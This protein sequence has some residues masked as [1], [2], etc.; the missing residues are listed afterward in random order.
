MASI[1]IN[2]FDNPDGSTDWNA[3]RKAKKTNGEECTECG[4]YILFGKG[5]PDQCSDCKEAKEGRGDLD[6]DR[7]VRCPKCRNMWDPWDAEDYDL[8][9]DG[10][11]DVC[12]TECDHEFEVETQVSYSFR[13]P[14]MEEDDAPGAGGDS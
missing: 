6:H 7:L 11:H 12:C 10:T 5:Y 13:S 3:Y 1:K 9:N 14:A 4:R 8:F 2:D